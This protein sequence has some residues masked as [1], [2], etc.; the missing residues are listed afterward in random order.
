MD[1][2]ATFVVGLALRREF[3]RLLQRHK[4]QFEEDKGILN[5][6]FIVTGEGCKIYLLMSFAAW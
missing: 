3:R 5:S 2:S 1:Q 4:L 6:Q